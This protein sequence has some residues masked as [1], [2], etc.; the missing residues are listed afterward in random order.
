MMRA[1]RIQ[2]SAAPSAATAGKRAG[3]TQCRERANTVSWQAKP[4]DHLPDHF[5]GQ[6]AVDRLCAWRAVIAAGNYPSVRRIRADAS[7]F[8]SRSVA[9]GNQVAPPRLHDH[10]RTRLRAQLR[11]NVAHVE[12]H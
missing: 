12:L 8:E 5:R 3:E 2:G 10:L 7:C 9:L 6:R 1:A 4:D 11:A